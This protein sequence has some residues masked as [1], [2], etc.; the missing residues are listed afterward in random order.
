MIKI[1]KLNMQRFRIFLLQY[2]L[3]MA[4]ILSESK[5]KN[6]LMQSLKK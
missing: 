3:I 5:I 1:I 6:E 2:E 4:I